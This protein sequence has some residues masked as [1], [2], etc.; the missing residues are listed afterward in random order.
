MLDDLDAI[1]WS[2]LTDAY[3]P[4]GEVPTLIRALT[5]QD[6]EVWV[7]ALDSL[8]NVICHQLC[9]VYPATQSAVPFLIELLGSR[10]VRCR[11]RIL[12]LLG[13]IAGATSELAAEV[14]GDWDEDVEKLDKEEYPEDFRDDL[15]REMESVR[16]ARQAV[17]SGLGTYLELLSDLDK[18]LRIN[19]PYT[20]A[21]LVQRA[22]RDMPE[23]VGDVEPLEAIERALR[24]QL[25]EEPNE[26]VRASGVFALGALAP[27]RPEIV[28]ALRGLVTPDESRPV[29]VAAAMSLAEVDR[30]LP[31]AA[32]QV[33]V[34][35]LE[36]TREAAKKIFAG[37]QPGMERKHHPIDR[38]YRE[39]GHPLG[40]DSGTG[41]DPAD[42]GADEDFRFPW[43]HGWLQWMVVNRV[44]HLDPSHT[45]RVLPALVSLV[46]AMGPYAVESVGAPVLRYVFQG[47]YKR[48]GAGAKARAL[49]PAQRQVLQ[50]MY[51][52]PLL[53]ATDIGNVDAVFRRAGLPEKR[54]Q[55]AEIPGIVDEPLTE[56]RAEAILEKIVRETLNLKD[57]AALDASQLLRVSEL[58]LCEIG[59]DLFIPLL[60]RFPKLTSLDAGSS[61]ITDHG[62]SLLATIASLE[63]L[64]LVLAPITD[65]GVASL[66]KMTSLR[67]LNLSTTQLTDAS[68]EHL[69]ALTNLEELHLSNITFSAEALDRLRAALPGCE[70]SN[71]D[72]RPRQNPT[73]G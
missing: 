66:A 47:K 65:A 15:A 36:S 37:D 45:E 35:I 53:W 2:G 22:G 51:D 68:L 64:S 27:L 60:A 9:S 56:P 4:A 28:A 23:R 41:Y 25:D 34:E 20:L 73:T 40:E 43:I 32:V 7:A 54:R 58:N 17:W 31:D 3:G 50:A 57:G 49:S 24:R 18:R 26:L 71:R 48:K 42:V 10:E 69:K 72:M 11:G 61:Q 44:C 14:E 62:V 33:L 8:A 46:G 21:L 63:E 5:A 39:S 12:E 19:V 52:N 30:A 67:S 70:I 16:R 6:P 1:D 29:R 59:S 55:W 13:H 38:F